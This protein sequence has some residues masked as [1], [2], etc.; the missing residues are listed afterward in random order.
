[1]DYQKVGDAIRIRRTILGYNQLE[2][3]EK[4]DISPNHYARIERG[5]IKGSLG[6]YFNIANALNIS[7]DSILQKLYSPDSD[8]FISAISTEVRSLSPAQREL[9]YAF[10][11]TLKGYKDL[12]L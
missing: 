3:A 12:Q 6:T 8:T 4:A 10:I 2:V 9:L 11:K 1:M 5:E 7:I